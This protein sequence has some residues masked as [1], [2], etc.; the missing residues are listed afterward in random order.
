MASNASEISA[1]VYRCKNGA[2]AEVFFQTAD[3][4]WHGRVNDE[5]RAWLV[6]G[7]DYDQD[8]SLELMAKVGELR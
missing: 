4:I 1:G 8:D 2:E 7:D 5:H 6:S 3:G